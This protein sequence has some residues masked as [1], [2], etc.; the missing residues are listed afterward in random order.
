MVLL[1]LHIPVL[2]G[3]GPRIQQSFA[4]SP[5]SHPSICSGLRREPIPLCW[6]STFVCSLSFATRLIFL[7]EWRVFR[8]SNYFLEARNRHPSCLSILTVL[9][10]R[11]FIS[12]R[13]V[14]HTRIKSY[15]LLRRSNHGLMMCV[16]PYS[17][18]PVLH[19][20]QLTENR[21]SASPVA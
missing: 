7:R 2:Q 11:S 5:S 8:Q 6:A 17:P 14:C 15:T 18:T 20:H 1:T 13:D 3:N 4:G 9:Q 16:H 12:L 10:A 19:I 21:P